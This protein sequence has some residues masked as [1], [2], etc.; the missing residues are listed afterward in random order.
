MRDTTHITAPGTILAWHRHRD[1][2]AVRDAAGAEH[3]YVNGRRINLTA[4]H[5]HPTQMVINLYRLSGREIDRALDVL[6]AL[7]AQ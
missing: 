1:I 2:A 5:H 6:L 3:L 4:Q 7:P